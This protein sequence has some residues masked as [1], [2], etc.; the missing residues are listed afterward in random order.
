MNLRVLIVFVL[1]CV[2][3]FS[4]AEAQSPLRRARYFETRHQYDSAH[5]YFDKAARSVKADSYSY[6]EATLG[7][8]RMMNEQ[9]LYRQAIV[10][11]DILQKGG[12]SENKYLAQLLLE[13]GKAVFGLQN[14]SGAIALF[15]RSLRIFRT[16]PETTPLDIITL[17]DKLGAAHYFQKNDKKAQEYYFK[18]L[19]LASSNGLMNDPEMSHV[20]MGI[21]NTYWGFNEFRKAFVYLN[22]ALELEQKQ[23]F[24]NAAYL[25]QVHHNL[26]FNYLD[27]AKSD[28]AIFHLRKA[29]KYALSSYGLVHPLSTWIYIDLGQA[30]LLKQDFTSAEKYLLEALKSN[31]IATDS[32]TGKVNPRGFHV[33]DLEQ[34]SLAY[35]YLAEA[36]LKKNQ[37]T[38]DTLALVQAISASTKGIDLL[39]QNLFELENASEEAALIRNRKNLFDYGLRAA[40]QMYATTQNPTYFEVAFIFSEKHK[41]MVELISVP[42]EQLKGLKGIP[43]SLMKEESTLLSDTRNLRATLK[44]IDRKHP[45]FQKS[46]EDLLLRGKAFQ[47]LMD[48]MRVNYPDLYRLKYATQP[49]SLQAITEVLESSHQGLVHYFYSENQLVTFFITANKQWYDVQKYPAL[50]PEIL[51]AYKT[52]LLN[53]KQ[54]EWRSYGARLYEL[55]WQPFA[56]LAQEEGVDRVYV[57]PEAR[58]GFFPFE[59]LPDLYNKETYLLNNFAFTYQM[60]AY[61]MLQ[62]FTV[63]KAKST[64]TF[65]AFIPS[66]IQSNPSYS[67]PSTSDTLQNVPQWIVGLSENIDSKLYVGDDATEQAFK[68]EGSRYKMVHF[69]NTF[70]LGNEE[71][72]NLRLVFQ[73]HSDSTQ[74]NDGYYYAIDWFQQRL[75]AEVMSFSSCIT[76]FAQNGFAE[77]QILLKLAAQYAGCANLYYNL[78]S[79][80]EPSSEKLNAYLYEL[81]SQG[82]TK[83]VALQLAKKKLI[84]EDSTLSPSQWGQMI[85]TGNPVNIYPPTI[86]FKNLAALLAIVVLMLA[87]TIY[88]VRNKWND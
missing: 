85:F 81:L 82:E 43:E 76:P 41:R 21:A 84:E 37:Q 1:L 53:N 74:E 47:L 77:G 79:V 50:L 83:D 45:L 24:P 18:A 58:M 9:G 36:Y 51:A 54:D 67:Q 63:V 23:R 44:V 48:K 30:H 35:Q 16:L 49:V 8:I 80:D 3:A 29:E 42:Y 26:A 40:L 86:D 55:F 25:A 5:F 33:A 2:C 70:W 28:S 27:L 72:N 4:E 38:G 46:V 22:L 10:Q 69:T 75:S 7:L 65:A 66:A 39:A 31:R 61:R 87:G 19:E 20:F 64:R 14:A 52:A 56:A 78:W 13:K 15:N 88:L 34:Q 6:K 12:L 62:D 11:V 32:L 71:K 68:S 59:T 17:Y 57:V 73:L 60:S